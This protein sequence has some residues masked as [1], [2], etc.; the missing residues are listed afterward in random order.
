MNNNV[1]RRFGAI[2]NRPS[3]F[4]LPI[5]PSSPCMIYPSFLP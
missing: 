2:Y 3:I 5:F 1:Q 4:K